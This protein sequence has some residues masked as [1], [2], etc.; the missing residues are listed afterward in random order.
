V[1]FRERLADYQVAKLITIAAL[2]VF[3][4]IAVLINGLSA[5]ETVGADLELLLRWGAFLMLAL[6]PLI[7][8][9]LRAIETLPTDTPDIQ[10]MPEPEAA[11]L[12]TSPRIVRR[13]DGW[14]D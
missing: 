13:P 12:P 14:D 5:P 10:Q 7:V 3:N 2:I 1:R 4:T 6:A 11:P 8:A 9:A